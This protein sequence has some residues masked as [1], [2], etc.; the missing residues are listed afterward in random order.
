V[1]IYKSRSNDKYGNN[2]SPAI[3]EPTGCSGKFEKTTGIYTDIIKTGSD[4]LWTS[5]SLTDSTNLILKLK[6]HETLSAMK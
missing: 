4:V 1:G 5:W 6:N 3:V 2:Y